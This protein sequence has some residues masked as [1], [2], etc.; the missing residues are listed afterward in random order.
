MSGPF[1]QGECQAAD[2]CVRVFFN[3]YLGNVET[4]SVND[5][6]FFCAAPF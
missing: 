5:V 2:V 6:G 1:E 4:P 3:M